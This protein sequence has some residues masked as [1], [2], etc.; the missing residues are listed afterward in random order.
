MYYNIRKLKKIKILYLNNQNSFA[1]VSKKNLPGPSKENLRTNISFLQ[2]RLHKK[3]N[4]LHKDV[5][6]QNMPGS[7]ATQ[8]SLTVKKYACHEILLKS[9][10]LNL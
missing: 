4:A 3:L 10:L 7:P 6:L 9:C 5:T 8:S 1:H 2:I